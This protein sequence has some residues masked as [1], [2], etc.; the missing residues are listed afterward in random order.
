MIPATV[1]NFVSPRRRF[2]H[3]GGIDDKGRSRRFARNS[4]VFQRNVM[5]VNLHR[6]GAE[7]VVVV[8]VTIVDANRYYGVILSRN[9]D[10]EIWRRRCGDTGWKWR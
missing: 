6:F 9:G 8:I 1:N 4:Q 5:T 7:F 3:G 10:A 2:H